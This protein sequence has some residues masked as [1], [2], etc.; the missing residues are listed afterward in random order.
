[1]DNFDLRKYLYNNPLLNESLSE[2]EY[3][4]TEVEDPNDLYELLKNSKNFDEEAFIGNFYNESF[5]L[6]KGIE[7][8]KDFLNKTLF[9]YIKKST[10][11]NTPEKVNDL[12]YSYYYKNWDTENYDI[13][14][15]EYEDESENE[16]LTYKDWK[17]WLKLTKNVNLMDDW[18]KTS[19]KKT[20]KFSQLVWDYIENGSKGDLELIGSPNIKL[21]DNMVVNG[22]L[23]LFNSKIEYLPKNLTIKGDL[24]AH[25][26]MLK[27]IPTDIKITGEMSLGK[28]VKTLPKGLH[29]K[30]L[31]VEGLESLPND[32]KIDGRLNVEKTPFAK[33]IQK[34]SQEEFFNQYPGIKGPVNV[35]FKS[36]GD[37][38]I[39]YKK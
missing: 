11:L 25:S 39:F 8:P 23:V 24:T 5:S 10:F 15:E 6:E 38:I 28:F 18:N 30:S 35:L 20:D 1:M 26:S 9:D 21:P 13:D 27:E 4:K 32:I 14:K 19:D 33:K 12:L 31:Y 7:K 34:L 37:E 16:Y 17:S 3:Y 22:E 29:I 36:N 2:F